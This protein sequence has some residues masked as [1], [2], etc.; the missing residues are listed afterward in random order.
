MPQSHFVV[1][2]VFIFVLFMGYN[3]MNKMMVII[4]FLWSLVMLQDMDDEV[5][6]DQMN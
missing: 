1:F 6:G 4:H 3:Y 2:R 5:E